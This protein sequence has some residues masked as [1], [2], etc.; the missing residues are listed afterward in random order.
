MIIHAFHPRS[1]LHFTSLHITSLHYTSPPQFSLP[2]TFGGFLAVVMQQALHIMIVR[3]YSCFSCP[4][5]KPHVSYFH[6]WPAQLYN[7]SL[8]C[9]IND[10]VFGRRFLSTKCVLISSNNFCLKHFSFKEEEFSDILLQM[11]ISFHVK[12]PSFLPDFD[13]PWSF[14]T[15][16]R[17]IIK[18]EIQCKSVQLQPS[19]SMRTDRQTDMRKLTVTFRNFEKAPKIAISVALTLFHTTTQQYVC[20][21]QRNSPPVGQVALIIEASRSH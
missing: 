19:F 9:L 5:C 10:T 15:G 16:F 6:L 17:K 14:L 7:I 11:C 1:S 12:Y 2:C 8:H 18:H 13:K 20:P 4:S 21:T 3:L